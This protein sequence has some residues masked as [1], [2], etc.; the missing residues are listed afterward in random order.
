MR[1]LQIFTIFLIYISSSGLSQSL[2]QYNFNDKDVEQYELAPELNEISGLA[3]SEKLNFYSHNDEEGIIFRLNYFNGNVLDKYQLGRV[4][5]KRDFEGIAAVGEFIYLVT[6]SGYILEAEE[7]NLSDN[8]IYRRYSTTL[9]QTYNVEGLCFDPVN[10]FLLLACKGY[11]V[12]DEF[13]VVY[14]F[15]LKTKK[16]YDDPVFIISLKELKEKFDIDEFTP[17][18]IEY[19]KLTET[20]YI[21][22]GK[23]VIIEVSQFGE[24]LDA[25]NL[26]KKI[27]KQ[28]EGI[29][30][31]PDGTLLIA[32]EGKDGNGLLTIYKKVK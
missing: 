4:P 25:V 12:S 20:Y 31:L 23:E 10:N 16:F 7:K 32:D 1:N 27:H 13:K 11:P 30:F 2:D 6:S 21:I 28:P 3:I 19:N 15:D 17:S 24:I 26:S 9:N 22:S 5:L 14:A 29:T 8:T 18:G